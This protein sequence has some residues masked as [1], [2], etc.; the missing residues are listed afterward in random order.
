MLDRTRPPSSRPFHHIPFP[1]FST[2]TLSNGIEVVLLPYGNVE[3][4]EVQAIFKLGK[5]HVPV[6]G[7][8]S[9]MAKMMQEGTKNYDSL[10]FSQALDNFGA[11]MSHEVEEES[12]AFKLATTTPNVKHTLP[13]LKECLLS[14]TFPEQEFNTMKIR[15]I[16]GAR[17][18]AQKTVKMASRHFGH[19]IFGPSHPYGLSVGPEEIETLK[20]SHLKENFQK[21]LNP[22]YMTLAVIGVFEEAEIMDRLEAEFGTL[23]RP[24]GEQIALPEFDFQALNQIGRSHLPKEGMQSTVRLGHLGVSRLHPD[25]YKIRVLNTILGGYF[26][27]R[28]MKNIR[29]EKGYTYGIYSGY[30]AMKHDGVFIIQGDVGNEHVEATIS[31]A[32]KEIRRLQDEEIGMD[33]L[34]LVKNYLLGKSIS[35]RETP[36]QMGDWLRFSVVNGISFAELDRRFEVIQGIQSHDIPELANKFLHPDKMLEVVAGGEK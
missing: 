9:H 33:E 7:L 18:N 22:S 8:L 16:Q 35:E 30:I 26:G 20:L 3:V 14:P 13:L 2:K 31:E 23:D 28:L 19:R 6:P 4:V 36:F 34:S 15:G 17:I 10:S 32:K 21:W 29:E 11:W 1:T 25:F 12:M 27:S 5:N 24:E